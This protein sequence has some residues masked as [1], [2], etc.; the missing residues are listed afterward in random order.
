M[1]S[2]GGPPSGC[3]RG[4]SFPSQCA[5]LPARSCFASI[6]TQSEFLYRYMSCHDSPHKAGELSGYCCDSDAAIPA[7]EAQPMI[8]TMQSSACFLCILYKLMIQTLPL[9]AKRSAVFLSP[10]ELPAAL[11]QK[12]PQVAVARLGNGSTSD[13]VAA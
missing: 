10:H 7:A 1:S 12:P 13:D 4:F 2:S 8:S 3:Y 5:L 9:L 11:N 6:Q